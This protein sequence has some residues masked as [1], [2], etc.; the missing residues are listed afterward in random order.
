MKR[1]GRKRGP[2]ACRAFHAHTSAAP[3]KRTAAGLL[4]TAADDLPRS[5][6]RGSVEAS[7]E[8]WR[9]SSPLPP[10]HAHT[11]AAP[12][13]LRHGLK[14]PRL[15][16]PFHAHTSAAPL[17]QTFP[18]DKVRSPFTFHAHTSAA[19]LKRARLFDRRHESR[20]FHAHT[21]AAPLKH[22]A[23]QGKGAVPEPST[24]TRARLR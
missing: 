9:T 4:P 8:V 2:G 3:L 10:F 16:P 6:E 11:S 14:L 15:I 5:H 19:P 7:I 20:T 1:P 12:L 13:K 18:R 23:A 21:S 24:L 22:A 17:K